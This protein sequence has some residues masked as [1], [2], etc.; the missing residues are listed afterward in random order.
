MRWIWLGIMLAALAGCDRG[1]RLDYVIEDQHGP[2]GTMSLR[3]EPADTDSSRQ[4][5]HVTAHATLQALGKTMDLRRTDRVELDPRTGRLLATE[6]RTR[7][8]DGLDLQARLEADGDSVRV[9]STHGKALRLDRAD[10]LV[11]DSGLKYNW[12]LGRLPAV[13]DSLRYRTVDLDR[14]AAPPVLATRCAD[15]PIAL[16]DTTVTAVQIDVAYPG[17]VAP[18]RL[19]IDPRD[20]W[21]LRSE[22][23]DG[24]VVRRGRLERGQQ[25]TAVDLDSLILAPVDTFIADER[26]I[27]AMTV[28]ALINLPAVGLAAEQLSVPGQRFDGAVDGARIDGVFTVRHEPFDAAL[29]PPFPSPTADVPEAVAPYLE[30]TPLIESHDPAV[31]RQAAD[32]TRGARHRWDAVQILTRWVFEHID[33]DIPGGGTAARTLALGRGECGSQSRLLAGLCRAAG[34]PARVVIGGFYF[35]DTGGAFGQH[36][37]TEVHMGDGGW[38][39][40]DATIGEWEVL[41]SGHVRL[42]EQTG[43]MPVSMEIVSFELAAES[44][45]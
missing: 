27:R 18:H 14:G 5:V 25:I 15:V 28:R 20:G 23:A 34:I 8:G 11:L 10:D 31:V 16:D 3:L 4:V 1:E 24:A 30:P 13:G 40:I 26:A 39:P 32:L 7:L 41:D 36:A 43:F 42:G 37:W 12:L 22:G 6:R 9:R 29:S 35:H 21:L 33:Y 17:A 19:W 45:G 44:D 2:V 38:V